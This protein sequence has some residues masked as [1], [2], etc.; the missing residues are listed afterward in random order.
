VGAAG[1]YKDSDKK[2]TKETFKFKSIGGRGSRE[3]LE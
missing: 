3:G 2:V 1:V